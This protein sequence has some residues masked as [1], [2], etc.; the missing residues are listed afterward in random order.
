MSQL[1][2]LHFV[3]KEWKTD[4]PQGVNCPKCIPVFQRREVYVSVYLSVGN[5]ADRTTKHIGENT[6]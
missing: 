6:R 2:F 5:V 3:G 4:G 1:L